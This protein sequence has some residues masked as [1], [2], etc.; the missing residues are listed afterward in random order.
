[1]AVYSASNPTAPGEE[2]PGA[3]H[4]AVMK[5][6]KK[7]EWRWAG[8]LR[9]GR[10]CVVRCRGGIEYPSVHIQTLSQLCAEGGKAFQEPEWFQTRMEKGRLCR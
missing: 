6:E 5:P 4:G 9:T 8:A 10:Y 2:G 3:V 7:L 1:M